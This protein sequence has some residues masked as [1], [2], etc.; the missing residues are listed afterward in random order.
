MLIFF[1]TL[2]KTILIGIL[3]NFLN[4]WGMDTNT[5]GNQ[6]NKSNHSFSVQL[7]EL[8]DTAQT[9]TTQD[10]KQWQ[11]PELH[12]EPNQIQILQ[13]RN[14]HVL[15]LCC[16]LQG[17]LDQTTNQ[18]IKAIRQFEKLYAKFLSLQDAHHALQMELS[19]SLQNKESKP[20]SSSFSLQN[21]CGCCSKR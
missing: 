18:K 4:G 17:D 11:D 8:L 7:S 3:F 16:Q 15:E 20:H 19:Q 14:T 1:D 13:E 6:V 12:S 21:W 2:K 5:N 10:L 9:P